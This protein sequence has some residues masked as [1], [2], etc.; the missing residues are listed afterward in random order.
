MNEYSLSIIVLSFEPHISKNNCVE[1]CLISVFN[2]EFSDYEVILVENSNAKNNIPQLETFIKK[3]N[4]GNNKVTIVNL[5]LSLS[6]GSA[7]NEGVKLATG[8]ALIFIDDDTMVISK[9]AFGIVSTLSSSYDFGCGA[10]RYWTDTNWSFIADDMLKAFSNRDDTYIEIQKN[11]APKFV[12][13]SESVVAEEISFIGN[14]GFCNSDCFKE[15]G[16]FPDFPI[17]CCEDD[18]LLFQLASKEYKF[19][20]LSNV[21]VLHVY[22]TI[23]SSRQQ[24]YLYYFTK[25]V[26]LGYYEFDAVTFISKEVQF[27]DVSTKLK[28]VQFCLELEDLFEEYKASKPLNLL[29]SDESIFSKWKQKQQLEIQDFIITLRNFLESKNLT[30]FATSTSLDFDN[31]APLIKVALK[32]G[33]ATINADGEIIKD[34]DFSYYHLNSKQALETIKPDS[35]LNQF[36]CNPA[37]LI[38]RLNFLKQRYPYC[39]YL[40]LALIGDDDLFSSAI[41]DELWIFPTIIEKDKR[42]IEALKNLNERFKVI[43]ADLQNFDEVESL[44]SLKKVNTFLCD[45]PYTINGCLL[46]IYSGLQLLQFDNTIKEF[47]LIA[48]RMMLG[49]D[50]YK[51]NQTLSECGISLHDCEK[52]ISHYEF[53]EHFSENIRAK[54]FFEQ[55]NSNKSLHV[56]STSDLFIYRTI[57]P[58]LSLLKQKI[59]ASLIYDHLA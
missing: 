27:S 18:Y 38:K 37:S 29:D 46:F 32:N 15:V 2:Q 35:S 45:P 6:R 42:I 24:E 4:K 34:F 54:S 57:S 36:P 21:E 14:F 56:S 16:G 48:N 7:R 25:L 26:E 13:G 17:G 1:H 33:Y 43:E 11:K 5:P 22:H 12:R 8:K 53:P 52:N 49:K 41:I 51:I 40:S 30:E 28:A 31:I 19:C 39:D 59:N 3:H 9:N 50:Y 58:N 23:S 47:Y 10:K 44:K 20:R 55:L